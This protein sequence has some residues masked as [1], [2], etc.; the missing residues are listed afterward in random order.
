MYIEE[1]RLQNFRGFKELTLKFPRNLAVIIGVNGSGK[2]S[3]LDAIAIFLSLYVTKLMFRS[4]RKKSILID[5]TGLTEDDIYINSKESHN[6]IQLCIEH[7]RKV[8]W[9]ITTS[10]DHSK[11]QKIE[12]KELT[13]H[14]NSILEELEHNPSLSLPAL[15][16]YQTH[17]MILSSPSEPIYNSLTITLSNR[18]QFNA[19]EGAFS[20]QLNNFKNFFKWFKE[21]EDY[22][23]EIR[24][25]ENT[26]YRNKNIEVVRIAI[27][28]FLNNFPKTHFSN[29]YVARGS[30]DRELRRRRVTATL[31]IDKNGQ[32][33]KLDKLS[34]GEKML[35]M[36]VTDLARRLAM[37]NPSIDEPAKILEGKGIVL[38][39]EVDLHLHPQW[40]R[41]V[42]PALTNT[43]P[44][45]QFI[46]TTHSPQVLSR[47][48]KENVIIL[49]DSELV[50]VTPYTFGKDSNSI[51]Y[52]LMG[53][54]ERPLE[55]QEQLNECF[56]LID[57]NKIEEAKLKLQ[58]LTA[59]LGENDPELVRANTLID[60][61]NP[62]E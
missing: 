59:L 6:S 45:C 22:E 30:T 47:V 32:T 54:T 10:K 2:S 57:D 44:N 55:V 39:D 51:L 33:F 8:F 26:D 60:F 46:V 37:L 17:R 49:E 15:V 29:L 28:K 43:F 16:Y 20:N 25:R 12:G 21:E 27:T 42:V 58:K 7:H 53:V 34:D 38:I 18:D 31:T 11:T 4:R 56:Q 50:E 5:K 9:S 24:L 52:E 36:V 23:N 48:H 40:Q 13:D 14:I 19:Y 41:I 61:F 35:L 3:I 1:L 62:G